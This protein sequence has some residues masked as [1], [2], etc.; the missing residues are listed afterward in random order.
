[1]PEQES[2]ELRAD[3]IAERQKAG[4]LELR[5][6]LA[7]AGVDAIYA[8]GLVTMPDI[9]EQLRFS[10]EGRPT[11]DIVELAKR[12]LK[13]RIPAHAFTPEYRES[14]E[15]WAERRHREQQRNSES[16]DIL[17]KSSAKVRDFIES[18]NEAGRKR[19]NPLQR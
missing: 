9:V 5:L 14:P 13:E 4:F 10:D 12:L 7:K 16:A 11:A 15:Q 6:E 3:L 8:R 18:T 1:M 19:P 17:G 2:R